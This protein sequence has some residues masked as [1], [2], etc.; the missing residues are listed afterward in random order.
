MRNDVVKRASLCKT[1][2]LSLNLHKVKPNSLFQIDHTTLLDAQY[3]STRSQLLLLTSRTPVEL[4]GRVL[5]AIPI[6]DID[7]KLDTGRF[8]DYDEMVGSKLSFDSRNSGM[9][10]V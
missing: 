9:N 2:V 3:D 6:E 7:R 8:L 4:S 5:C 1:L 10:L